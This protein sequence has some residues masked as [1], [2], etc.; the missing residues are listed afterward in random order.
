LERGARL[1]EPEVR[2]VV[3]LEDS[4]QH[5][6]HG[7]PLR[8]STAKATP[9]TGRAL[10]R[11]LLGDLSRRDVARRCATLERRIP[12][13][14]G[15]AVEGTGFENRRAR[16]GTVS[17]NLTPSAIDS[18]FETSGPCGASNLRPDI[19]RFPGR[20]VH[21]LRAGE[22]AWRCSLQEGTP[23]ATRLHCGRFPER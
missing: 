3:V 7:R 21:E 20:S 4:G 8:P 18:A 13:R 6:V 1:E 2:P 17:S 15:R 22:K 19:W 16:K 11:L 23:S 14:D 9:V 10:L 5:A 12:R